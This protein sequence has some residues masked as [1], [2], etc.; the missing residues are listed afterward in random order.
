MTINETIS[1]RSF[2]IRAGQGAALQLIDWQQ[3]RNIIPYFYPT[4]DG[5]TSHV[6]GVHGSVTGWPLGGFD[7]KSMWL[8]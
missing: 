4:T 5:Y 3:G 2:L 7:F 1:H 8:S 6:S